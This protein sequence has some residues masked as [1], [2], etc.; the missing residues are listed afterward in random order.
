MRHDTHESRRARSRE[1][2]LK[3]VGVLPSLAT[4]GNLTCGLGAIYL[5]MLAAQ[6]AASPV[7]DSG[8]E[9]TKVI[10]L[11]STYLSAAACFLILGMFFDAIDGR[12]ARLARKTSEFGA[13]L[14]SLADIVS[15]G[16]APACLVLMIAKPA[17][18]SEMVDLTRLERAYWRAEWVMAAIYVCCTAM[19]LARFNVENEEDESAHM[20]FRGL[21]SPGA[22]GAIIAAVLL[23]EH[24]LPVIIH[25][26]TIVIIE[27][28]MPPFALVLGLLMVSP[29]RYPHMVNAILRGRRPFWQVVSI[30][31]ILLIAL[32][33]DP[34][35]TLAIGTATYALYGPIR[36]GFAKMLG[37]KLVPE[38]VPPTD[39]PLDFGE[40][41]EDSDE[42]LEADD[43]DDGDSDRVRFTG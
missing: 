42:D 28:L 7:A 9:P 24:L 39:D 11:F 31:I 8:T 6:A 27:R 12:L 32:V 13:Q 17:I 21:P 15:F 38:M 16:V 25:A 43:R 18:F 41:F 5:C 3:T 33:V 22:A 19:R 26:K 2:I 14:D 23:H 20:D 4:L 40:T 36:T 29:F 10:A 30:V 1:R 34:E 35:I 37:R